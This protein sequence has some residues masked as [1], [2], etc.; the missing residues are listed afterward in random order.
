MKRKMIL[1]AAY[2]SLDRKW[3]GIINI[4]VGTASG[5]DGLC[6]G[7]RSGQTSESSCGNPC[8]LQ[9]KTQQKLKIEY[10]IRKRPG[11]KSP[12]LFCL[13]RPTAMAA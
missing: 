12:G 9:E 3:N 5:N 1:N 6:S 13:N 11:L 2:S 7:N 8:T 4:S 10:D